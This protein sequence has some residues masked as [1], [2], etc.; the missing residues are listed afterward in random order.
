MDPMKSLS[1]ADRL[2]GKDLKGGWRVL[3]R[4][5]KRK[6]IDTGGRFSSGY[7]VENESGQKGFLK[8]LDLSHFL[9]LPNPTVMLQEA[10]TAYNFELDLCKRC[11][12]R[13]L[14][15][16]VV[17]MD[18]GE[19]Q[20][21]E[22]NA[23]SLVPYIIF[24]L[25]ESDVRQ[26]MDQTSHLDTAWKLRTLHQITT[27]VFQLHNIGIRHRD[28]KPSNVMVF[29]SGSK[30][31]DLGRASLV[32]TKD[33]L[34]GLLI[35]G[36]R[37][38]A[39]PELHY[40]YRYPDSFEADLSCDIYLVGSLAVFLFTRAVMTALLFNKIEPDYHPSKWNGPFNQ[41]VPYLRR[42]FGLSMS[43]I[44]SDVDEFLREEF[45]TVVRQLCDPDPQMRGDPTARLYSQ[46]PYDLIRYVSAFDRMARRAEVELGRILQ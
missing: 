10:T 3:E 29:R 30:V 6:G 7:I 43:V 28:L 33:L 39:P 44:A 8:A 2:T 17:P 15:R 1:F 11:R 20:V 36:D 27:G 31:G 23:W 32:G 9:S 45:T 5:E 35:A 13:R 34:E 37:T 41:V 14:D 12:D 46:N 26:K 24:E 21:E 22:G 38:Y 40:Q 4:V 19:V 18:D 16:V 25:G 42:A